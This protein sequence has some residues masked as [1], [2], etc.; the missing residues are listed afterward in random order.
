MTERLPVDAPA[1]ASHPLHRYAALYPDVVRAGSLRNALQAAAD[2]ARCGLW[3]GLTSSPGWRYVAAEVRADGRTATALLVEAA[4]RTFVVDCWAHGIRMA[5]GGTHDLAEAAGAMRS[6]H[7]GA[8]V[9]ELVARWAFLETWEL[10]EAH[11]RGEAVPARW[12][13]MREHAESGQSRRRHGAD[14][15]DL[16]EA[17]FAQPRL[18]VLSPGSSVGGLTFS[19]RVTPPI[20]VDLPRTWPLGEGRFKVRFADGRVYQVDSAAAAVSAILGGLPDD[21]VPRP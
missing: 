20:C 6:W 15:K 16:V 12:R 14:W 21:A 8:K 7:R 1:E 5:S 4:E 2:R 17:A 13:M 19:R 11:E 9:R 18:R 3:C 10:A